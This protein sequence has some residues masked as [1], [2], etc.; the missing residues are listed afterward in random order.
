M[1]DLLAANAL[2]NDRDSTG[3]RMLKLRDPSRRVLPINWWVRFRNTKPFSDAMQKAFA[4]LYFDVIGDR[5][6]ENKADGRFPSTWRQY[7]E[8]MSTTESADESKTYLKRLG[9]Q[10][11]RIREILPIPLLLDDESIDLVPNLRL[12]L[13]RAVLIL[14]GSKVQKNEASKFVDFCIFEY[15]SWRHDHRALSDLQ[16]CEDR[17]RRFC[18]G[19]DIDKRGL[20]NSLEKIRRLMIASRMESTK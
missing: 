8:A 7:T 14:Y 17:L 4:I 11:I 13:I 18:D 2:N 16:V 10:E 9:K 12:V 19:V 1:R 15:N 5:L 20:T 6:K 3:K